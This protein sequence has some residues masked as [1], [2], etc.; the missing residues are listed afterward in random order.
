MALLFVSDNIFIEH[1]GQVYSSSA[2]YAFFKP[3]L[4]VFSNITVVARVRQTSDIQGL[5]LSSG[6]GLEFI[7]L[8]SIS[9]FRS[10][11]GLRQRY[12]HMFRSLIPDYEGV[13]VNLP[14]E[15][16]LI[17]AHVAKEAGVKC[18]VKVPGC[19]WDA[20]W[21]YGGVKARLYAPYLFWRMK[22]TVK[23]VGYVHYVTEAFLQKRYPSSD[24]AHTIGVSDVDIVPVTDKVIQ[25]RI[26]RIEKR[27][28]K[29]I[30][31]T[32]ANVNL[33]YKGIEVALKMIAS[34]ANSYPD[35]EYH[36]VG[37]GD[38]SKY[39]YLAKK[40]GIE[41]YL[42]WS[43]KITH[44]EKLFGWLDQIDIYLQ[45]SLTEGMPR[46]VVEAM[47]RGCP[48]IASSVGGIPELLDESVMFPRQDLQIFEQHVKKLITDKSFTLVQA[49][50]NFQKA[51]TYEKTILSEKFETFLQNFKEN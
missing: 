46:S 1:R 17:A 11:F 42:I 15:F 32:I 48:V 7:F 33:R 29:I 36:I 6:K 19:A 31:G 22:S 39:Q 34:L 26:E 40:L 25:K 16:G 9:T 50:K 2:P 35:I 24:T 44:R 5:K 13:I 38:V 21:N 14:G 23:K 43:G 20:M 18:M 4:D 37:E 41:Q 8:E 3:Y 49:Q 12:E 27:N 45:P 47:S 10:F 30:F 28:K 51:K